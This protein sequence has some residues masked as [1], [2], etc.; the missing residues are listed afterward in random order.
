MKCTVVM[1]MGKVPTVARANITEVLG[2]I[3]SLSAD[4]TD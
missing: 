3:Y 4:L 2:K 1:G